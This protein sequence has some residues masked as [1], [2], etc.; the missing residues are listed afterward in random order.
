MRRCDKACRTRRK[1]L[2]KAY[3]KTLKTTSFFNKIIRE[4]K[5]RTNNGHVKMDVG[6]RYTCDYYLR[7][8]KV[9][10]DWDHVHLIRVVKFSEHISDIGLPGYCFKKRVNGRTIH[11]KIYP[12]DKKD[13]PRIIVDEILT[14]YDNFIGK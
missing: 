7:E 13:A 12:I 10:D 8:N 4:W 14:K 2:R 1:V 5:V 11:S 9:E 6:K 3:C